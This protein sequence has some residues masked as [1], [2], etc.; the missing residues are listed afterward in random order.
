MAETEEEE[1][2][3]KRN[4][5]N[6]TI[7][8][9]CQSPVTKN[10]QGKIANVPNERR[11]YLGI[12][13]ERIKGFKELTLDSKINYSVYYHSEEDDTESDPNSNPSSDPKVAT[14]TSD[15]KKRKS[16]KP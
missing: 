3:A 10:T 4:A 5:N 8:I 14:N 7:D 12:L 9:F 11:I 13:E 1:R 6:V 2:E 16:Y 15:R